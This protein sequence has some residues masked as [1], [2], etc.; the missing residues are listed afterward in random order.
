MQEGILSYPGQKRKQIRNV[1]RGDLQNYIS[2]Y[3]FN[4][5]SFIQGNTIRNERFNRC[6]QIKSKVY[7]TV[8]PCLG[9]PYQEFEFNKIENMSK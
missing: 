5:F 1:H 4:S 9:T 2:H 6:L 8:G 3:S 7:A